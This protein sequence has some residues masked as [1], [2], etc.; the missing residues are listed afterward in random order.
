MDWK[1]YFPELCGFPEKPGPEAGNWDERRGMRATDG[2]NN[3][4]FIA[5]FF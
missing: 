5:N 1:D 3:A 2:E 4:C